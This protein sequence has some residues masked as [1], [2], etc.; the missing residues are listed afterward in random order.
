MAFC[1]FNSICENLQIPKIEYV[2]TVGRTDVIKVPLLNS[3]HGARGGFMTTGSTTIK[4]DLKFNTNREMWQRKA[5]IF[6]RL[7]GFIRRKY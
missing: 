7:C 6:A 2:F 3:D 4:R 5:L 1:R